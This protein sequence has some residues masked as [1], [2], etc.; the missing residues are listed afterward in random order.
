MLIL[1]LNKVIAYAIFSHFK[2]VMS[3]ESFLA[4]P[5]PPFC[6]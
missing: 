5:P 6:R 1:I 2:P 3:M 4:N